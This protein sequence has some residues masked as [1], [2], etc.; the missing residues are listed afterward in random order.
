MPDRPVSERPVPEQPVPEAEPLPPLV[1]CADDFG[2]SRAV[3][4]AI[5]RLARDRC[6]NAIGCMANMPGWGADARLLDG[7]E[8]VT[9]G[10]LGRVQVG[11]HLVLAS[12]RPLGPV[13]GLRAD[14]T[15]PGPDR[16]LV[17]A[18]TGRLDLAG[19]SAEIDRQFAAFRAVRG[20]PPDFV[21]AHQHVHVYP[22]IRQA[23]IAA[24][25]R[26]AP[27]AWVRVP[28]D[29]IG[30][31]LARPFAAKA[32]GSTLHAVGLRR[33]LARAGL[34]CNASFAGHYDFAGSFRSHLDAFL[35][36]GSAA[37]LVM[38][39]PGSGAAADDP[40]AAARSEEAAVIAQMQLEHR[41]RQAPDR[42][43]RSPAPV[44]P[45][46]PRCG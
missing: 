12:E 20:C 21:D 2:M 31:M 46:A 44:R 43:R 35:G 34:R 30:A 40:I 10:S 37:H 41:F 26:H 33:Q 11:L 19:I 27:G 9:C 18:L 15:M 14:G 17:R 36:F 45:L 7:I 39:H 28:G 22:G 38:C 8:Q 24:T 6:I 13:G 23:V 25:R 5:A 16:M 32:I 4:E 1:L 3:S 42:T 29:R